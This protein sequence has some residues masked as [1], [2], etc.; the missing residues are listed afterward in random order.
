[1]GALLSLLSLA[2]WIV[3]LVCLILTL[4]KMFQNNETTM[5]IICIVALLFCG[6]GILITFIIGWINASR[7]Q[8][9]QVMIV[10]TCCIVVSILLTPLFIMFGPGM[11]DMVP[12]GMGPM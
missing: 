3:S 4:V 7:W 8:N 1:M 10:W 6:L 12:G 5:G 2:I 9:Q 11:F